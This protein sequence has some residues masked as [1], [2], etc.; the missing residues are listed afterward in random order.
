[1]TPPVLPCFDD[2][3]RT[4]LHDLFAWRRDVRHFETRPVDP[5]LLERLLDIACFAPSVG[6]SQPWRFVRIITPALRAKILDHVEQEVRAAGTIYGD[7]ARAEYARLKLQGLDRAPEWIAVYCDE[8]SETGRGLGRQTMPETLRYSV[9]MAIHTLWLAA[10]AEGLGLGW[11]SIL[12]PDYIDGVLQ[13]PEGWC[14]VALL[15][16]GWP[17]SEDLIPEL[18]RAGW[19]Q[20]LHPELTRISR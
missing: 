13:V 7:D 17:Q 12:R 18:E 8:A 1:M 9:T 19:Q 2:E 6:H 3:F 15:C 11:V 10:R 5:V 4:S 14:L 20:R 16:L